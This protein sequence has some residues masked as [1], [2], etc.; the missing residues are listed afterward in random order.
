MRELFRIESELLAH[1]CLLLG[2]LS[3]HSTADQ[4][5]AASLLYAQE[6][7]ANEAIAWSARAK[8][9]RWQE[10][11]VESADSAR[12][13][14]EC[15][16]AMPIRIQLASQEANAAALLGDAR[17]AREALKRAESAAETVEADSGVSAWSFPVARQALFSQSVAINTDDPAGALSAAEMADEAWDSGSPKVPATWAQMRTG[18]AIAHVMQ[19]S[20]DGAIKE[21]NAVLIL[22]PDLRV[23]TVTAFLENLNRRLKDSRYQGGVEAM[24]LRQKIR[25]FNAAGPALLDGAPTASGG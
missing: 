11:L 20:L 24:S 9:L 17:R 13:G 21:V 5:G 25:D 22:A 23:S 15:S 6:A 19:G 2:D 16:P 4:Y 18:A 1:A 7:G 3:Q 10:R 8:T 12:R 14:Y